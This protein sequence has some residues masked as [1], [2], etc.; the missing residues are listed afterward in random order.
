MEVGGALGHAGRL[1]HGMR[2]DD[3][4][5]QRPQLID[6]LLDLGGGDGVQR[7]AG[8]IHEDDFRIHGDGAGD[9]QPLLLTAGQAGAR[10]GQPILDLFP[11]PGA[12]QGF[13]HDL[14]QISLGVRQSMNAGAIG[15]V[16]EDAF[17]E[18]VGLLEH[19]ADLGAQGHDIHLLAI[20][21]GAVHD[22]I[23]GD[24]ASRNGVVH[25]VEAAQEGGLAAARGADQRNDL[26]D[27]DIEVDLLDRVF[28]PVIH[29][30]VAAGD[31][32]IGRRD[33]ADRAAMI[34]VE[35]AFHVELLSDFHA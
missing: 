34:P 25:A 9:A 4:G 30:D 7:R 35:G 1:L 16:L 27:A 20:D 5:I 15:D 28:F 23:A 26:I 12:T 17:R 21:V 32:G 24:A 13:L 18:G 6:Q 14:F 2:D 10:L 22:D 3:D 31:P 33:L 19:H 8:F 29:I 11:E